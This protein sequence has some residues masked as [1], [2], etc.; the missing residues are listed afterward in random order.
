MSLI[1]RRQPL[2]ARV[3]GST[4]RTWFPPDVPR[5]RR[6]AKRR[7]ARRERRAWVTQGKE[8]RIGSTQRQE[9]GGQAVQAAILEQRP[10]NSE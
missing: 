7:S 2:A 10:Q 1:F 3:W 6:K 4:Y 5:Q 9:V 8:D